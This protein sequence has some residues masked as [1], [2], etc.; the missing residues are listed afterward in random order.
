MQYVGD[1]TVSAYNFSEGGGENYFTAGGY[2]P[3]PYYTVAASEDF[4]I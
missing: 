1:Y 2:E 4:P 3:V